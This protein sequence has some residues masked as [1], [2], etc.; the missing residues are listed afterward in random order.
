MKMM[1]SMR[2]TMQIL[3]MSRSDWAFDFLGRLNKPSLYIVNQQ[4]ELQ[5][6]Y[7][8]DRK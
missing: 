8:R 6:Y 7:V 5:S 3:T 1:T 2:S 4:K